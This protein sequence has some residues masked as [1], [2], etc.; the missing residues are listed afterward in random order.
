MQAAAFRSPTTNEMAAML[1]ERKIRVLQQ[2]VSCD[3][4]SLETRDAALRGSA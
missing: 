3:E 2:A 4:H 1:R